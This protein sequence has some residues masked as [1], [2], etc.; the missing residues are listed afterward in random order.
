MGKFFQNYLSNCRSLFL[1]PTI[2]F[3]KKFVLISLSEALA[4]GLLSFWLSAIFS[5]FFHSLLM[6]SMMEVFSDWVGHY[7]FLEN[8]FPQ[9]LQQGRDFLFDAGIL[10]LKPF[11][12][13]V[14][15]FFHS[16]MLYVS[17]RI[18]IST[19]GEDLTQKNCLKILSFAIV[20]CWFSVIPVL[21]V[22]L[23]FFVFL[24]LTVIGIRECFKVS[25]S[26]A[27]LVALLPKFFLFFILLFLLALGLMLAYSLFF[28]V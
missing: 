3:R 12:A 19:N 22:L 9:S 17:A 26:R 15:L 11:F 27:L 5:F 13:L 1:E 4:I 2:F 16:L 23:S 18:F 7:V 6:M 14:I 25:T 10:L 20:A 24:A 28:L 21:G 8:I